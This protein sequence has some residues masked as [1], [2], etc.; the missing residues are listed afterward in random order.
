MKDQEPAANDYEEAVLSVLLWEFSF[1]DKR[2]TETKIKRKLR[3]KKLGKYDQERV[4]L[5]RRFKDAVQ[6]EAHKRRNSKY[7]T[8]RSHGE[9]ADI[10][11]FDLVTMKREMASAF[12]GIHRQSVEQFIEY[13]IYLYY[14]R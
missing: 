10:K 5:L 14:I 6:A 9:F 8:G 1:D 7:H 2:E 11:D 13:G 4:V 3:R 12:P